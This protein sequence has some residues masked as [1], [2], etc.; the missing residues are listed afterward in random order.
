[1]NVEQFEREQAEELQATRR[2]G[3][4]EYADNDGEDPAV[5]RDN[6]ARHQADYA[7]GLLLAAYGIDED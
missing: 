6:M 4:N 1:M 3:D 5:S 7:T 2:D